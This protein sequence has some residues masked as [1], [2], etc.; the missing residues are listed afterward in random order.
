MSLNNSDAQEEAGEET[1][2][3]HTQLATQQS[4]D[5]E[6]RVLETSHTSTPKTEPQKSPATII[7][8]LL[9]GVFIANAEGS[10]VLA[11]YGR[12]SSEFNDLK[13]ASWL[14]TSYVLAVSAV[15]PIYGKL[16]DIYGRAHMLLVAYAL[17][18]LGWYLVPLRDVGSWRSYVNI[19]A[20]TGRSLGGPIGGYLADTVGWRWSFV[21]QCPPT[22]FG[23]LLVWTMV[24]NTTSLKASESRSIRE[25]L[26]RVDLMGA[27]ILVGTITT[28]LLPLQLGGILIPWT[29][30][31]IF[32]LLACFAALSAW[33]IVVEMRVAK[34]PI[35]SLSML[36]SWD[37][38]LPNTVMFCQSAAQLGMMFTV[39][40]FFE[41][42]QDAS[43]AL[44]G[45]HLFPAVVAVAVAGLLGGYL[46]KRTR[47]YKQ[48]LVFATI[49]SS[50]SY[51]LLA[52]R[53]NKE[54]S[55]GESLF[56]VPGGFGNGLVQSA[57]FVALTAGI[58]T[59]DMAMACS[60]FYMSA[61][62]GTV[63]GLA[64]TNAVLQGTLRRGLEKR[65]VGYPNS[66]SIIDQVLSNIEYIKELRG[67]AKHI[68]LDAYSQAFKYA[69]FINLAFSTV[70]F[71]S[72]LLVREHK[73]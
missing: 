31:T 13:N 42:M 72:S 5:L 3:L 17:F 10:L 39:P 70:A 23:M 25:G 11:T 2:L 52:I 30:P 65:L 41:V 63:V 19:V 29:H 7:S 58:E 28:F 12:I 27:L 20:T 18:A 73:M 68:V 37:V 32:I 35:L 8:V 48:L 49:S 24:P 57:A 15:Q 34:E 56:I 4:D 14:V 47:R 22:M 21:G 43:A 9:I 69:H 44:A 64:S 6:G 55:F 40:L 61:N 51:L 38:L 54:I 46:T 45:A 26:S 62:T 53:W 33:F 71:V 59:D 36:T 60:S 67:P 66:A 50:A 16:S 1:P